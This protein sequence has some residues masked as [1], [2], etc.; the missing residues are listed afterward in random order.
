MWNSF[1]MTPANMIDDVWAPRTPAEIKQA[2][3]KK[4]QEKWSSTYSR[5]LDESRVCGYVVG[6][7]LTAIRKDETVTALFTSYMKTGELLSSPPKFSATV[8]VE[9]VPELKS[10]LK[11]KYHGAFSPTTFASYVVEKATG[12]RVS[13][14]ESREGFV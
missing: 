9:N 14:Q 6:N 1:A 2:E 10:I 7:D 3:E 12:R 5:E 4:R 8:L 13:A 11:E